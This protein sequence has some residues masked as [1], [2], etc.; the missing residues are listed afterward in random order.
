M[1]QNWAVHIFSEPSLKLKM[2]QIVS[3]PPLNLQPSK[4][5]QRPN[6]V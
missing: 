4:Y 2:V 1:V 5:S 6:L 3:E